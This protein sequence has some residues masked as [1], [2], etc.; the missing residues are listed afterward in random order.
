MQSKSLLIA[1]AAF[2]VTATGAQAY[3]GAKYLADSGLST[4]QVEALKEARDLKKHGEVDKARDLLVEAGITEEVMESLRAAAH[5]SHE[6]IHKA[7]EDNNYAAFV[8]AVAGTPLAESIDSEA[9]FALFVQA[10]NLKSEG[11]FTEAKT[12]LTEL[13]VP[14]HAS[15]HEEK[16]R[17]EFIRDF[18]LTEEQ[19][20]ALRAA[21]QAND[22]ETVTAILK[23]AGIDEGALKEKRE[24]HEKKHEHQW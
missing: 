10:H 3:V 21:R 23:E 6:A 19:R 5:A 4:T 2:A 7:V 13:G 12:I 8:E 1:I 14:N 22:R 18:D 17:G 24:K 16:G 9:D 11:K 20:D 15:R